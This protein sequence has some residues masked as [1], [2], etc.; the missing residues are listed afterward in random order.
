MKPASVDIDNPHVQEEIKRLTWLEKRVTWARGMTLVGAC[1]CSFWTIYRVFEAS[2]FWPSVYTFIALSVVYKFGIS[3][4]FAISASALCFH[5]NAVGVWLPTLSY[6]LAAVLLYV[7]L[8]RD[9]LARRL[10]M[11]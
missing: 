10:G 6:F 8:K 3:P 11:N 4:M 1:V 7:D 9:N 5:F 2:G